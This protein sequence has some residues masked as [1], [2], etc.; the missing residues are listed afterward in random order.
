MANARKCDICGEYYDVPNTDEFLQ[1]TWNNTSM[2]R[3][4]RLNGTSMK[5]RHE[6]M[7]F[8]SCEKCL[9]DV[10]DYILTKRADSEVAKEE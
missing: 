2:V 3:V 5:N 8:D 1:E 10:L 7:Q 9:Q 4:L 6:V